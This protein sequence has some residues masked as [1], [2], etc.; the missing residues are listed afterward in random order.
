MALSAALPGNL[1][2]PATC[3]AAARWR[4]CALRTGHAPSRRPTAS[5]ARDAPVPS[6]PTDGRT[7]VRRHAKGPTAACRVR[8]GSSCR[9]AHRSEPLPGPSPRLHNR[10]CAAP[11]SPR[12]SPGER[13]RVRGSP[14]ARQWPNLFRRGSDRVHGR[15]CAHR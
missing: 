11:L 8:V 2:E 9:P 1:A 13:Q 6:R 12:L 15:G 14:I 10:Q 7:A 5:S 3:G 4:S